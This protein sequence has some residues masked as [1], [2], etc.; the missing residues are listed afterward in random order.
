[1]STKNWRD[2]SLE[3]LNRFLKDPDVFEKLTMNDVAEILGLVEKSK[4]L[5]MSNDDVTKDLQRQIIDKD[6]KIQR[7]ENLFE[8][9][10]ELIYDYRRS[11]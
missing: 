3:G 8:D 10:A 7:L 11:N 2:M 1:M 4:K 9:I 5:Q 6:R